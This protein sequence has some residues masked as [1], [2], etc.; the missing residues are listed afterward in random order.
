MANT[1]LHLPG[2]LLEQ[3]DEIAKEDGESRNRVIVRACTEL[4]RHRTKR[5]PTGYFTNDHLTADD[6]QLLRESAAEFI[7]SI[8][9]AR[10]SKTEP[11]L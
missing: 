3:L 1:S 4:V 11:P 8:E 9:S 10:R 5:W 2:E 6:L 7:G